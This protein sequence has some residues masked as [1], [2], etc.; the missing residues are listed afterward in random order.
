MPRGV[1]GAQSN[2]L[3]LMATGGAELLGLIEENNDLL[4]PGRASLGHIR[5]QPANLFD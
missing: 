1:A 3:P 2:R 5:Y 4:V